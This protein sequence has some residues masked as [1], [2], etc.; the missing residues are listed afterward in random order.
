MK[1][2]SF[3]VKTGVVLAFSI[4]AFIEP[5]PTAAQ[6]VS[7]SKMPGFAEAFGVKL[8]QR[9]YPYTATLIESSVPGNILWPGEQ[10]TFT[11]QVVNNT[12]APIRMTAKVDLVAY[13][14][15]GHPGDIWKPDVAKFGDAGSTPVEIDLAA[16]G[17]ATL[18]VSPQVPPKL[19]AYALVADLGEKGRQ[20]ITTFVRTFGAKAERVQYPKFCLDVLP[21]DVLSRLGAQA[22][23]VAVEYVPI[24]PREQA[25]KQNAQIRPRLSA[26]PPN[27]PQRKAM[28]EQLAANDRLIKDYTGRIEKLDEQLKSLQ[29]KN[30]A[31]L[32]MVV[33]GPASQPLG[34]PRPHL[35]DEG[36]L[37]ETKS[38]MAWL[39]ENDADFQRW[40]AETATKYGWPRGPV[41]AFSLWNEPWEGISISGWGADMLRYRELYTRMY[42]GIDQARRRRR[43]RSGRRM[44][45]LLQRAG[46]A[47][48]R[49]QR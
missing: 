22:V 24:A 19:G 10:P 11:V 33:A 42:Q 28:E 25:E 40:V 44:R 23:R 12:D 31:V 26:L 30:V 5:R 13:G 43:G 14:T 21:L 38:D 27:D 6:M 41:N 3:L 2:P 20:F 49:R 4:A 29:E 7:G 1:T 34:R 18:K 35:D 8:D 9:S 39:P 47:L 15:K 37:Q 36:I 45:F 48:P 16:R 32:L 17:F 46:Q